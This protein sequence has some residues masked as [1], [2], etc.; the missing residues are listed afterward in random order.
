MD[1][2][3][4]KKEMN[5]LGII[6][7]NRP[8]A[9]NALSYHMIYSIKQKLN[10]WNYD[11]QIKLIILEGTGNRAFCAGGDIKEVYEGK[12][13][14]EQYEYIDRFLEDEYKLDQLVYDFKKP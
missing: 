5:G 11:D 9:L 13:A 12:Q 6:T 3:I 1:E 8:D 4:F 2:V 10:E 7:L 14:P